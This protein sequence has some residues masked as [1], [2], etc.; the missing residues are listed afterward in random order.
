MMNKKYVKQFRAFFTYSLYAFSAIF[1]FLRNFSVSFP[2]ALS[3]N[4]QIDHVILL[5][6]QG[7]ISRFSFSVF[8]CMRFLFS[9]L[10]WYFL[11]SI[12][13]PHSFSQFSF[14]KS[15]WYGLLFDCIRDLRQGVRKTYLYH[16]SHAFFATSL[17]ISS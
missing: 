10:I 14:A 1:S 8:H 2:L 7:I 11:R 6:A 4:T 15:S 16:F 9:R 3:F 13:I 12:S 5:F 17:L